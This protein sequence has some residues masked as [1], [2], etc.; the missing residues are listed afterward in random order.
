M[1][2]IQK[3]K[4]QNNI[5][6]IHPRT[7]HQKSYRNFWIPY[8]I[9]AIGS[10]LSSRRYNVELIDNNLL[11]EEPAKVVENLHKPDLVGISSM[12]GHQITEGLEFSRI[13]RK[14]FPEVP[15]VYGGSAPTMLPDVFLASDQ[16]DIIVRGQGERTFLE[17]A[18]AF[19]EG[20][21]I[22]NILGVSS[23]NKKGM[24]TH[25]NRRPLE[26]REEFSQY[27]FG[28]IDSRAYVK[29]DEHISD[30]VINYVASQG[31]TFG[32]GFCSE[33]ALY[34]QKWASQSTSRTFE[35]TNRLLDLSEANA[36]KFYDANFFVDKRK[37]LDYA[38]R[39]IQSK[40]KISWAAAAHPNNLLRLSGEELE[41][42][43]KSG[44]SRILIGAESGNE[45]E[46]KYIQKNMTTEDVI[47]V[48]RMLGNSG[49]HGSFTT[50]VGYPGFP[51]TNVNKTLEFGERLMSISNLHEVKAHIYAPYPGTPLYREAIGHGFTPPSSLEEWAN[52]DYYEIQTPWVD[53]KINRMV[54]EF[55]KKNCPYIL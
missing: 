33:V 1:L 5:L 15:I 17:V 55:N 34:D 16:V 21:S 51:S 39:V 22:E 18:E 25:A 35:D 44:C 41:L 43:R 10:H 36:I 26:S 28:L 2:G 6:L 46:L 32:C 37:V 30:K 50:I 23:K 54:K 8:S 24:I 53:K 19:H 48:A 38:S 20:K 31:C 42:I 3:M 47:T 9:L 14:R 13:I 11:A 29:S 7:F 40:R 49:I 52:Y 27:N 12:I 4:K 45:E